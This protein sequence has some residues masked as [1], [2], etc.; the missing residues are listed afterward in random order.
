MPAKSTK[1]SYRTWILFSFSDYFQEFV[2]AGEPS[3][4][5]AASG[6]SKMKTIEESRYVVFRLVKMVWYR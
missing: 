3:K 4:K 2:A 1:R 6:E 5:G